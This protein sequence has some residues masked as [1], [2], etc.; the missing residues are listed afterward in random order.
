MTLS[1]TPSVRSTHWK[2]VV[3]WLECKNRVMD[4][5]SNRGGSGDVIVGSMTYK[6]CHK[7]NKRDYN[8]DIEWNVIRVIR[9][10]A[11]N[12]TNNTTT[13]GVGNVQEGF[14]FKQKFSLNSD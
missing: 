11:N 9:G 8:I 12:T 14:E 1:T 3:C 4:F 6:R 2:Q 13:T 7:S 5:D 10:D